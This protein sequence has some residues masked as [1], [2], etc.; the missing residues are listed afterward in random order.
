MLI[1]MCIGTESQ[2]HIEICLQLGK[3]SD[4]TE[5][6]LI[7]HFVT[8]MS[9][10]TCCYNYDILPPNFKRS[11]KRLNEINDL[12]EQAKELAWSHINQLSDTKLCIG[13]TAS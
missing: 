3:F 13:V 5:Q 2:A 8:G 10:A 7:R 9:I 12:I 6:A 4:N 1:P 11:V